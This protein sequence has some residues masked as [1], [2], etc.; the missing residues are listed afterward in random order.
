[1]EISRQIKLL[2]SEYQIF[3]S[4]K[5]GQNHLI[6]SSALS[7]LVN[8]IRPN[9]NTSYV[10]I[11]SGFLFL[12]RLVA[13]LSKKVFAIE[14]DTRFSNFYRDFFE[15]PE[16]ASLNIEVVQEDAL[17]VD[18]DEFEASQLF[19]NIPYYISTELFL[20]V[21]SSK[22]INRAV[23]LFQ[24]EFADRILALPGTPEY[25][26]ISVFTDFYFQKHF[27]KTFPES[28]F[29]PRPTV[30]SSLVELIRRD[31]PDVNQEDFFRLVRAAFA[32][33]RKKLSNNLRS[34]FPQEQVV[35]ALRK[36]G[37]DELVRAE[38]LSLDDF[39]KLYRV[40]N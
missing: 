32:M 17:K 11:G 19:G 7:Y 34:L 3:P 38:K 1:M 10:E 13:Q 5:L 6:A 18:L 26:S 20:K 15:K 40:L 16:N 22:N 29:Y 9:V 33:R 37:L 21:A 25:S 35:G 27:L 31:V 36:L 8:A 14:K 28:F 12:T 24:K 23:I 39:V 30:S 4:D 2:I